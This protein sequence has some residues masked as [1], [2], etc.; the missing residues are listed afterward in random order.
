[1]LRVHG[2]GRGMGSE[3]DGEKRES[4]SVVIEY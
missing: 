1:M 2:G 4:A 3:V